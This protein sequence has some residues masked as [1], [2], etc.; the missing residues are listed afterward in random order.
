MK[1][2]NTWLLSH[3][4]EVSLYLSIISL[5]VAI[6]P[7]LGVDYNGNLFYILSLLNFE[8]LELRLFNFDVFNLEIPTKNDSYI[9]VNYLT[10]TFSKLFLLATIVYKI[11]GG[12]AAKVLKF[13][14]SL[15][16]FIPVMYVFYTLGICYVVFS[17]DS[18]IREFDTSKYIIYRLLA[19]FKVVVITYVSYLY[20]KHWRTQRQY[21]YSEKAT[22]K[23]FMAFKIIPAKSFTRLVHL[24]I[25]S[26]LICL[27]FSGVVLHFSYKKLLVVIDDTLGERFGVWLLVVSFSSIY[28]LISE[29]FLKASPAKYITQTSIVNLHNKKVSITNI[30]GRTLCRRIPFNPFSFIGQ[31][32]WHDTLAYTTVAKHGK[33]TTK[34][35]WLYAIFFIVL[36]G[37][38]GFR[39]LQE[40]HFI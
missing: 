34:Y 19:L 39:I 5:L 31:P 35:D 12:K 4:F 7:V 24:I 32:G 30:I 14:Y 25:D 38:I 2:I 13:C 22:V 20:L 28:Y 15:F 27:L 11:S 29:G 37:I 17:D 8:T 10:L 1:K 23:G 36:L 16:L 18:I 3:I 21:N 6:S 9:H 26:L 40:N 33:E